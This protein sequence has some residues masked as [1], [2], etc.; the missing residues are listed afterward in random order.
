MM[1]VAAALL[2]ASIGFLFLAPPGRRK[3]ENED[4]VLLAAG[5]QVLSK[6]VQTPDRA[7]Q[8]RDRCL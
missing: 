2:F 1:L 5:K 4:V 7:V 3:E 8:M 6:K